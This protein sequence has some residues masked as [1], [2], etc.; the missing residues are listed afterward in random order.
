MSNYEVWYMKPDWFSK[1]IMAFP[2]ELEALANTHILLKEAVEAQDLEKLFYEMQGEV[3]SPKGEARGLIQSK[4]LA[5]TSMSVGDVAIDLATREAWMVDIVG[6]R[7]L[8]RKS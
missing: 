5:H 2:P 7:P 6:F 4:G 1:G 8:G 3:W